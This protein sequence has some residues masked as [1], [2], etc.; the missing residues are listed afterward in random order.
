MVDMAKEAERILKSDGL[1][2]FVLNDYRNKGFLVNMHADFMTAILKGTNLKMWD[3]VISEVISQKLRFRK[4]DY[5]LRRTVKC[6][7]YIMTFKK[8]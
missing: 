6:H 7:E 5:K 1:A 8:A 4:E 3:I 2:N